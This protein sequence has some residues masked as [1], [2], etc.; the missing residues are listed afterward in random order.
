VLTSLQHEM[1]EPGY[2]VLFATSSTPDQETAAI[3]LRCRHMIDLP[4][5]YPVDHTDLDHLLRL[6][7]RSF[8]VVT[9]LDAVGVDELL[10]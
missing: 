2:S 4:W 3:D 6:M 8:S 9:G 5:N 1:A 7:A 10:A